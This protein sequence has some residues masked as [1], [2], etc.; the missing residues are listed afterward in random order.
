MENNS[1]LNKSSG[2]ADMQFIRSAFPSLRD[3]YVFFDNAGG[4]QTLGLVMDKI[5][6]YYM[7]SNVQLGGV[8]SVSKQARARVDEGNYHIA[9]T[10]NA[11]QTES[12]IVGSSTTALIRLF[13][14]VIGQTLKEG[15]EIIITNCDPRS[16]CKPLE[17]FAKTGYYYQNM[18]L[19]S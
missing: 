19:Q 4:S 6:D 11:E 5:T 13:S 3:D 18:D 16:E 17:R 12:V 9:Q 14:I 7:H 8:Y 2:S 15:D 1:N 10:L